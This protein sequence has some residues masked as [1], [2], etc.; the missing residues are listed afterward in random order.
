MT[1][2]ITQQPGQKMSAEPDFDAWM[3]IASATSVAIS[4]MATW[5]ALRSAGAARD[6]VAQA[7]Q[8]QRANALREAS[9]LISR[10]KNGAQRIHELSDH[11][12]LVRTT[13]FA[14]ADQ[15]NSWQKPQRRSI[16]G[17]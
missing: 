15:T 14:I 10:A 17:D 8:D 16:C 3:T 11:L 6:A 7:A 9:R 12:A 13:K 5:V 2:R 4:V 1:D